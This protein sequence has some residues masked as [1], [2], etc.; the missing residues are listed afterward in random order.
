[1]AEDI[2]ASGTTGQLTDANTGRVSVF[3]GAFSA[4]GPGSETYA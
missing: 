3:W 2:P 1:V 4:F